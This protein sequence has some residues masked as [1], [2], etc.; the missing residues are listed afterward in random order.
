MVKKSHQILVMN[1]VQKTSEKLNRNF[2]GKP[3]TIAPIKQTNTAV[4]TNREQNKKLQSEP[5]SLDNY[6]HLLYHVKN[7]SN[8]SKKL[9]QDQKKL[10]YKEQSKQGVQKLA[11]PISNCETVCLPQIF[12][13][14][15]LKGRFQATVNTEADQMSNKRWCFYNIYIYRERSISKRRRKKNTD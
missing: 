7:W 2:K 13:S 1:M 4:C 12:S 6:T 14:W 8:S 11:D 10:Q 9:P 5:N 3:C 15:Q